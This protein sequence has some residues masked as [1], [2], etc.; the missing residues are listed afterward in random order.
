MWESA[1]VS[2]DTFCRVKF[3]GSSLDLYHDESV[4]Y[5]VK[6]DFFR[7]IPWF[8]YPGSVAHHTPWVRPWR[9]ELIF[10]LVF[11]KLF[12]SLLA[13]IESRE[14]HWVDSQD[15]WY[16]DLVFVYSW[17]CPNYCGSNRPAKGA[18]VRGWIGLLQRGS[19][20]SRDFAWNDSWKFAWVAVISSIGILRCARVNAFLLLRTLAVHITPCSCANGLKRFKMMCYLH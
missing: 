11:K 13:K 18:C 8:L 16:V 9:Y 2:C 14:N 6:I 1:T 4:E 3:C 20:A 7:V 17:M 12:L 15:V 10:F 19:P 5:V